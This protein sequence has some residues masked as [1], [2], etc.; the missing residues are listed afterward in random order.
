PS[1]NEFLIAHGAIEEPVL[2]RA[3]IG[4]DAVVR[5]GDQWVAQI[6]TDWSA[7]GAA[8]G[9]LAVRP[10]FDFAIIRGE[11]G[12]ALVPPRSNTPLL[13][14]TPSGS[15]CGLAALPAGSLTVGA[16]GTVLG[17]QPGSGCTVSWWP[18]LL[19]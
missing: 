8:P 5:I 16:D 13:F 19:R 9:F 6:P 11:R 1:S 10:G 2:V 17:A 14:F 12:Y 18:A 3:L 15:V 4:G 7:A